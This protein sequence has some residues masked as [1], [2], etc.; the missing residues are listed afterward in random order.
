M[1]VAVQFKY[2][3]A[4]LSPQQLGDLIQMPERRP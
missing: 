3:P 4:P 2:I 1:A